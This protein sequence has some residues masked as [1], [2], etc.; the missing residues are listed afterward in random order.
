MVEVWNK[1]AEVRRQQIESGVDITFCSVFIPY[2]E[3]IVNQLN[4]STILEVG[5]GTGHL[6]AKLASKERKIQAI[7][8]SKNM[9]LLASQILNSKFVKLKKCSIEDFTSTEKFDLILSHMCVQTIPDLDAFFSSIS[10][11]LSNNSTFIF[12]LPHPCFYNNYKRF[13]NDSE[14][15]YMK[16]NSKYITLTI[17]KDPD[18]PIE[19]IPY[20]H[21]SLSHYI[22]AL[23]SSGMCLKDM[24]EIFP[25]KSIQMLYGN[26][27]KEPRY[28]VIH[29][30]LD[31]K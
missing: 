3:E 26:Q 9:C 20:N 18:R 6:S 30:T 5:C 25:S 28:L 19:D 12:S 14:Y 10:H 4:P 8:T 27:W 16:P 1:A 13:F 22:K 2:F 24:D 21:R 7:D 23:K 29:A 31:L 17:T 11:F 15:I